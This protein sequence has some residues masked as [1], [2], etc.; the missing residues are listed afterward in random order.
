MT[1]KRSMREGK[2]NLISLLC[3]FF[4]ADEKNE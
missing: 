3:A 1:Q 2:L 4:D